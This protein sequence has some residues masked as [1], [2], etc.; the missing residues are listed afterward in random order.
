MIR[1]IKYE[2]HFST[3]V[4]QKQKRHFGANY[5]GNR[6]GGMQ[7]VGGRPGTR[8]SHQ[9]APVLHSDPTPD[10]RTHR[11]GMEFHLGIDLRKSAEGGVT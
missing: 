3:Y 2:N 11:W 4:E 7:A 6:S 10:S 5:F 8:H 9:A 1:R